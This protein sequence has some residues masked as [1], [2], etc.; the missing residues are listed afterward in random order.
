MSY[1]IENCHAHGGIASASN[2]LE[3]RSTAYLLEV[4]GA[5]CR[6]GCKTKDHDTYAECLADARIA[7]DKSS[8]RP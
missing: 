4:K 3:C 8:L 6:T 1:E 7:V 2:C 5:K